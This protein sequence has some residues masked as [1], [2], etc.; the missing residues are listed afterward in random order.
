VRLVAAAV[1]ASVAALSSP[2]SAVE[3]EH[4]VGVDAGVSTLVMSD[5]T[6][7]G[8]GVG[9]HWAYGLSDAFNLMAEGTWSLVARGEKVQGPT[10]PRTRPTHVTNVNVGLGY[11]FDVLRWVPYAGALIG[12]YGL[13]GGTIDGATILP[14]IAIALGLDYRFGRSWAAGLALRQHMLFTEMST[15][16]SFTHVFARFEYTWGW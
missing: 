8:G 14:G 9:A 10:T 11:V 12:G 6:D 5:K 1:V 13:A 2:A 7:L 15:Y 4:H 16:P 3:H